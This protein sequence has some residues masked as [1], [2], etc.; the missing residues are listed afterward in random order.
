LPPI[1]DG[2]KFALIFLDIVGKMYK[3]A[4]IIGNLV[5]L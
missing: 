3:L 2:A 1:D 5:G 4:A